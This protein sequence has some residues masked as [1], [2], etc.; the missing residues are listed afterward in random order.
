MEEDFWP[1]GAIYQRVYRNANGDRHNPIRP[2][3]TEWYNDGITIREIQFWIDGQRHNP[4]G[5]AWKWFFPDGSIKGVAFWINGKKHNPN[6]PA[7]EQLDLDGTIYHREF[8]VNGKELTEEE[9][10]ALKPT[11]STLKR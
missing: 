1:N 4:N 8:W 6:G 3:V 10:L 11:K 7:M 2:A 9:F 5:P